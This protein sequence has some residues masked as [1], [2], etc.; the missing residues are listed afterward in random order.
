[1]HIMKYMIALHTD[2]GLQQCHSRWRRLEVRED[3]RPPSHHSHVTWEVEEACLEKKCQE[4]LEC[5]H[6]EMRA[7]FDPVANPVMVA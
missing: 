3:R 7:P 2:L 4:E 5:S 1:M 6:S